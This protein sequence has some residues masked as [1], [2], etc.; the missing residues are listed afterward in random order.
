M[1]RDCFMCFTVEGA[2]R[3][4]NVVRQHIDGLIV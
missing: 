3:L 1:S 4:I 2:D